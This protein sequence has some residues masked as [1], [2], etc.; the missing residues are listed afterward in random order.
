MT[1]QILTPR[2]LIK[3]T[4]EQLDRCLTIVYEDDNGPKERG[5]SLGICNVSVTDGAQ[6][7][8]LGWA[9]GK[10]KENAY[11]S[12]V[13]NARPTYWHVGWGGRYCGGSVMVAPDD[14][15]RKELDTTCTLFDSLYL[16][17][18][19]EAA[20]HKRK[21]EQDVF[22]AEKEWDEED[23]ED[24]ED[25]DWGDEDEEDEEDDDWGDE[26]WDEDDDDWEDD[27]LED[28]EDD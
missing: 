9:E 8:D 11:G 17:T 20:E 22:D 4:P 7:W 16:L 21:W 1:V 14:P 28:E 3:L 24:E 23:E 15:I 10:V 19:A 12:V 13:I 6:R 27:E 2:E 26:D 18:E 5:R 25:D